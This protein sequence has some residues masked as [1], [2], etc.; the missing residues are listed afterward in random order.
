MANYNAFV[1]SGHGYS[2]VN[3]TTDPG[4]VNGS[5]TEANLAKQICAVA[6]KYLDTTNLNIHYDENNYADNDLA[7]NTYTHKCGISVHIN[8]AQ[9]ATGTEIF[10]PLKEK[11]IEADVNIVKKISADLGIPNRG[12]KSRDYDSGYYLQRTNGV[13]CVG[14]DYYKEI[15]DAWNRGISL[16]ILEVGFIQNDLAKIQANIEDIGHM[17]AE[18]IGHCCNVKIPAKVQPQASVIQDGTYYRVVT[19][20]FKD[21]AQAEKRIAEL[22][23]KGFDSFIAIYKK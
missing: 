16:A 4:A 23:A 8:S 17:V 11:N 19:G 20:S 7:G 9:G 2:E 21:R 12:V 6:K 14:T 22:K 15:R 10:V 5:I 1:F 13:A 18:Y 3:K